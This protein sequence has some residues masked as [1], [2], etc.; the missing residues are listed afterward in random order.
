MPDVTMKP[1]DRNLET[2]RSES[3]DRTQGDAQRRMRHALAAIASGNGSRRELEAAAEALVNELR[4]ANEP[5]EQMLLQ[6][7]EILAEGGLRP[8]YGAPAETA[9]P[10]DDGA[11]VYRDVIAW[12]IRSYYRDDSDGGSPNGGAAGR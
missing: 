3:S 1:R 8:T 9:L 11:A 7:K 12:S 4:Q 5:P 10:A 6:I 2:A